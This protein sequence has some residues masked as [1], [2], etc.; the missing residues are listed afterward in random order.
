MEGKGRLGST[1]GRNA[2]IGLQGGGIDGGLGI[3][4]GGRK[5]MLDERSGEGK[6]ER[7]GGRGEIE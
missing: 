1:Y 7:G 5:R 3:E 2:W 4:G 6:K